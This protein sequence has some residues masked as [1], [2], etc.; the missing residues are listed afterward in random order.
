MDK[1]WRR[2]LPAV[3]A[4]GPAAGLADVVALAAAVSRL[5]FRYTMSLDSKAV[6]EARVKELGLAD[7]LPKMVEN[8]WDT[9]GNFAFA[10]CYVP[11]AGDPKLMAGGISQAL[12]T[13]VCGLVV[14]IP[15]VLLH[16]AAA[17]KAKRV[18]EVLEEQS[19]GMVARQ[20]E[21]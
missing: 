4:T 8:H 3:W 21:G 18:E 20:I 14:A 11:G 10:T 15:I 13:T 7:L 6:F 5:G 17:S 9:H 12:V 1:S 2:F 16:T 19:A